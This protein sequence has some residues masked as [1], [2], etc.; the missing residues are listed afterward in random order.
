MSR[1]NRQREYKC[2]DL[3]FAK[4]K[5]YPHWPARIDEIPDA[6]AKAS[7][8]KYQVFFFGTHETAYL[9]PKDIFLYEETKEKFG[10]PNKRKGFSEGLW[11]IENTPAVKASGYQTAPKES[12]EEEADADAEE[13][14]HE[15]D[16]EKKGNAEGSSDEEGKLIID[17]QSKEKNETA[18]AKRKAEDAAESSP[19]RAKAEDEKEEKAENEE[20][21]LEAKKTP[22][23]D[24]ENNRESPKAADNVEKA[25]EKPA[26][27]QPN[28]D[29]KESL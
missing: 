13:D 10:K 6:T 14:K 23:A 7:G 20:P 12:E 8:N 3:V 29:H 9:G 21:Q 5:G 16:L 15:E 26:A 22:D 11:E 17:E 24:T 18:A 2:G 27:E 4:M 28:K 1:S 25:E 19:K